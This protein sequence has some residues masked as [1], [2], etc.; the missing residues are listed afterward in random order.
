[1]INYA[2]SLDSPKEHLIQ[3]TLTIEHRL[4][5]GQLFWLPNWIPG[6][7]MIR[8][9][10]RNI[11]EIVAEENGKAIGL[12]KVASNNWELQQSVNRLSICYKVYAWDLSVRSAHFDQH[13]CFFNG[14]SLFLAIKGFEDQRHHVEIIAPV[15]KDLN[16]KVSTAMPQHECDPEGFGKYICKNY[17]ELIDHPF[18]IADTI[19][20]EFVVKGVPHQMVF[21]ESPQCV[22]VK[23]IASD[24]SR[25]CQYE[26]DFFED[27]VPPFER[28]MFMIFVQKTGFGGLEHRAS[29]ALHCGH[30]DLPMIGEDTKVKSAGYQT[31]LALCSHEYF[32]SWNVKRIKPARFKSYDLQLEVN[33]E[34]LWFFEGVTSYYDE[35]FLLR[36]GVIS[37]EEY[38]NMIAKNITRYMKGEGRSVQSITESSFDAWS[39]FYK[40]DENAVNSIVSYYVK[41]G[42]VAFCLDFE[43]RKLT[44][45][46]KTLDDLMRMV[47][48]SFGK[49][50]KGVGEKD[51]Q[52]SAEKLVGKPMTD[53]FEHVLYSTDDLD[54]HNLFEGLGVNYRLCSSKNQ[55]ETGGFQ[56]KLSD[57]SEV[58]SLAVTHK[59]ANGGAEIM[60]VSN[61]GAASVSG[62]AN[63]DLIIAID[64]YRVS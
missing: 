61:G 59:S 51:I 32:H 21:T 25:I 14:T 19:K 35:L 22:D 56:R 1:M 46:T 39:K 63:K 12:C 11:M 30:A 33:T 48:R 47:W 3:I 2:V 40:Q 45:E 37:G 57:R 38:L 27:E 49:P 6:S 62:L 10:S 9:F 58:N 16:W 43:I 50:L 44:Q 64:G 36:S 4:D 60:S 31:F 15:L 26:C 34:L 53:F 17:A 18:E 13:H 42:L 41:G 7:Y 52:A 28:Y 8:E 24:V 20:S 29:T 54:L 23:R 5:S 55:N